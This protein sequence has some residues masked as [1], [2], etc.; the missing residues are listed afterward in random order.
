M[1]FSFDPEPEEV[2]LTWDE[3]WDRAKTGEPEPEPVEPTDPDGADLTVGAIVN[4]VV[5]GEGV[6]VLGEVA[7]VQIVNANPAVFRYLIDF[8]DWRGEE[9]SATGHFIG[10]NTVLVF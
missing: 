7:S 5:F 3:S 9:R 4:V 8:D 10:S 2:E 1:F 6:A